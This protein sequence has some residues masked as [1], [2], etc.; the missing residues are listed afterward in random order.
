MGGESGEGGSGYGDMA[1]GYIE[2]TALSHDASSGGRLV[3]AN[4]DGWSFIFH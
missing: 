2:L 3:A 1:Y 4:K